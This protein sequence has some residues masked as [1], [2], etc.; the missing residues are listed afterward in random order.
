MARACHAGST[1]VLVV[2]Q[3]HYK[4]LIITFSRPMVVFSHKIHE[5]VSRTSG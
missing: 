3:A 5:T 1:K 4:G 2:Y